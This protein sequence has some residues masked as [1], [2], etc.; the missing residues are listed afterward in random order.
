M[1][2]PW[3]LQVDTPLCSPMPSKIDAT[4]GHC[5]NENTNGTHGRGSYDRV[6][7]QQ[8]CALHLLNRHLPDRDNLHRASYGFGLW[9]GLCPNQSPYQPVFDRQT[10]L[11]AER[12]RNYTETM[13]ET[14]RESNANT[15]NA[16][17]GD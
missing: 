7:S 4:L 10:Y 12:E 5:R 17:A 11:Q 15:G 9:P 16:E 6:R 2:L 3:E 1:D 14:S 13:N 8:I